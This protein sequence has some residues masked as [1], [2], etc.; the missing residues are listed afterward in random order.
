M[1]PFQPRNAYVTAAPIAHARG[2]QTTSLGDAL[3]LL[4]WCTSDGRL[5]NEQAIALSDLGGSLKEVMLVALS[6][7]VDEGPK[8]D[9]E[10]AV[11]KAAAGPVIE[12]WTE[13]FAVD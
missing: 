3:G 12:F 13:E 5:S 7:A 9:I 10:R 4:P 1:A 8:Q 11:G 2:H 6:A